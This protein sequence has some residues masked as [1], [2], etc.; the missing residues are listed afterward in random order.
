MADWKTID[1]NDPELQRVK[2]DGIRVDLFGVAGRRSF[3]VPDCYWH[4]K[5]QCWMTKHHDSDGYSA[6]RLPFSPTHWQPIPPP[7]T[8]NR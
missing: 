3:R 2:R 4:R 5:A 7:P 1:A 6:L 8:E